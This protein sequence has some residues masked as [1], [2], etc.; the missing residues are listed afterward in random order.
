M[1]GYLDPQSSKVLSKAQRTIIFVKRG[2]SVPEDARCC[3]HYIYK[4]QLTVE[5]FRKICVFKADRLNISSTDFQEFVEDVRTMLFKQKSF[6]L[7][8]DAS[9]LDEEGYRNI[10]GLGKGN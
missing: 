7:F 3:S 10:V 4:D 1:C 8:D 2:V 5:S 6:D 9:C